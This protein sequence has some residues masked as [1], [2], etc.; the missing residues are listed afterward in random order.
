MKNLIGLIGEIHAYRVLSKTYGS[1]VVNPSCWISEN[2]LRRFPNNAVDD[3]FGC[4]FVIRHKGK[5]YHIEVKAME[6]E[7]ESFELGVT[8]IRHAVEV[9]NKKRD[10]FLILHITKA[11]S[12]KP[13]FQLLPNPYDR[14]HQKTYHI[15]NAGLRIRYKKTS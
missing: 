15:E 13:E 11:L 5:V 3:S 6:G 9:A 2:S 7:Q 10:K 1:A 4:D 8:E 12:E 14:E